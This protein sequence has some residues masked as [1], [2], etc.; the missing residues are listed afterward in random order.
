MACR[1]RPD[2]EC[3]P[4]P[5]RHPVDADG[6]L[7]ED[8]RAEP[9]A[10]D[11]RLADGTE[12]WTSPEA[13][14][15]ALAAKG[16][17]A[18]AEIERLVGDYRRSMELA[19]LKIIAGVLG[20][21]LGTLTQR[22][23]VYQLE[24]ERRRAKIFRRV[25]AAMAIL[26]V[27]A[28][29]GGIFAMAKKREAENERR[30]AMNARDAEA[31]QRKAADEARGVAETRRA[32]AD[33]AKELAE[34]RRILSETRL[35]RSNILLAERLAN[36]GNT[37]AAADALVGSARTRAPMGMGPSAHPRLSGSAEIPGRA[38]RCRRSSARRASRHHRHPRGVLGCQA[39]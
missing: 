22:D 12:G 28:V 29:A 13:Y 9:I 33:A 1:V 36:E 34:Q 26:M 32:E 18:T 21:P 27:A 5:L 20:I 35:A 31:E 23:K 37:A 7:L 30:A 15:Q 24:K 19:K 39:D 17:I 14:R 6:N 3:F 2:Q 25:A 4:K 8:Q 16:G 10:A 11:F 38:Q